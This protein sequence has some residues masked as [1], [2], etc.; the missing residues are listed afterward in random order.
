[1][2]RKNKKYTEADRLRLVREYYEL[3]LTKGEFIRSR[4]L[5][6]ISLL[7]SWLKRYGSDEMS[8]HLVEGSESNDQEE[9]G[10]NTTKDEAL[11]EKVKQQDKR[12]RELEKSLYISQ[13]ETKARDMLID[14]AEELFKIPIRKKFGAK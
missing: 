9:T 7:N 13:L 6:C 14:R 12:I 1:M 10:M 5:S 3:G 2:G 8:V 11:K 4:G